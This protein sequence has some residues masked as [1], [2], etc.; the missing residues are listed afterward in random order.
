MATAKSRITT[1]EGSE[2]LSWIYVAGAWVEVAMTASFLVFQ[3]ARNIQFVYECKLDA[4]KRNA[5]L[6]SVGK[7][8]RNA[9]SPSTRHASRSS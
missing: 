2:L 1:T 7:A 8:G 5:S 4:K 9:P 3:V 6:M